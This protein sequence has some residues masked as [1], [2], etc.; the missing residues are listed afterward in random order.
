M[1]VKRAMATPLFLML[2]MAVCT[3][4]IALAQQPAAAAP[5]QNA[6]V[7]QT[8]NAPAAPDVAQFTQL[9]AQIDQTSQQTNLDLAQLRI[10]KWKTGS[11][12][13]QQ[14]Q[15]DAEALMK[16]LSAALPGMVSA[17]RVTP[18]Q[19][20]P[21]LKLYRDLNALYEV[22]AGL[23]DATASYGPK[24]DATALGNDQH[25][26]DNARRGVGEYLDALASFRDAQVTRLMQQVSA[27]NAQTPKKIIVDEDQPTPPVRRKK[28]KAKTPTTNS[29][30]GKPAATQP[31]SQN[32]Q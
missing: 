1:K 19:L 24:D 29:A 5:G 10:E 2:L 11:D 18:N 16:N 27:A 12:R 15:A 3:C 7:P 13:K 21:A 30:A 26:L 14:A 31:T 6:A 23:T 8:A 22:L 17:S 4:S 9:L 20:T 32:P 25:A 28:S